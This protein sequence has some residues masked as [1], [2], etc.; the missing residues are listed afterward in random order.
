MPT[1]SSS[2]LKPC[3]T[4][5][6]AFC[7]RLRARPCS[8]A[9]SSLSRTATTVESFCWKRIAAGTSARS[10][11][12]GPSTLT[13]PGSILT[14]TPEGSGIGLFPTRDISPHLAQNFAAHALLVGVPPRHHAARR[15]QNVDPHAAEDARNLPLADVHSPPRPRHPLDPRNDRLIVVAVLEIDLDSALALFVGHLEIRDVPFLFQDAGNL[16][17]QLGCRHVDFGMARL[18]GVSH[19][20]QHIGDRISHVHKQPQ[21]TAIS[22]QPSGNSPATLHHPRDLAFEREAAEAEPAQLEFAQEATRPA[23]NLAAVAVADLVFQ[24]LRLSNN[25]RGCRHNSP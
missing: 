9:S 17:L 15:S 4:P 23:T 11:P 8:A 5:V 12:L 19:P 14:F 13:A 6:T 22:H 24:L 10:L 21:L 2:L 20:R 7:T 18:D 16:R 3:V 1:I 25:L